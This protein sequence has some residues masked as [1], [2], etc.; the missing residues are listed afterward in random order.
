LILLDAPT[1]FESNTDSICD[2]IISVIADKN[3]RA[4][5]IIER[6]NITP[7][8]AESRINSQ[9]TEK[10]FIENSDYYIENNNSPEHALQSAYELADKIINL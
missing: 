9:H 1:L 3:S 2:I 4:R 10:F 6:D 5:R 7:E 8:Q